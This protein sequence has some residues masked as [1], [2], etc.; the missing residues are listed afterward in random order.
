MSAGQ[1]VIILESMK[2]ENSITSEYTGTVKRI[3]TKTG[4]NVPAGGRLIELDNPV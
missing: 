2:M 1:E 3:L 4:A